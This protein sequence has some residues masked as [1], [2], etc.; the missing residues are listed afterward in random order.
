MST[1]LA[2]S[3]YRFGFHGVTAGR[4]LAELLTVE[5]GMEADAFDLG[6]DLEV[7]QRDE[8]PGA[9]D[10]RSGVAYYCR[11]ET[12]RRAHG[13][14]MMSLELFHRGHPEVP[15]HFYGSPGGSAALPRRTSTACSIP[16][17]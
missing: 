4:W 17:R 6:S 14:A 11:P 2:E 12:P 16:R 8:S 5:Y 3:T 7:Y 10:L 13:L 1:F 15:I 9:D